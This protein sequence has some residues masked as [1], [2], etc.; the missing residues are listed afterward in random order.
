APAISS[1]LT[2]ERPA[3]KAVTFPLPGFGATSRSHRG[4][5]RRPVP[6]RYALGQELPDHLSAH[7]GQAIVAALEAVRQAFV[8]E[9]E[10]G[11]DRGLEVV[12]VDRVTSDAKAQLVGLAVDVAS[13]QA[14][15]GQEHREAVGIVIAA[16]ERGARG[17][18]F[19]ERRAAE[20]AAEDD[21]GL[22]EQTARFQ[23]QDQ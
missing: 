6:P 9:A 10:R 15:A 19:A 16:E 22:V 21:Q 2:V 17:P 12:D 4:P 7:I 11:Q 23:V 1:V 14:A 18:S 3:T 13:L 20:L 8:V 5:C